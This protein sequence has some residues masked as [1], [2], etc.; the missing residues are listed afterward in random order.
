MFQ[1]RALRIIFGPK[2]QEVA[3]G[4][5]RLHSEEFHNLYASSNVIRV[6]KSRRIS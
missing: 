2:R 6:I 4:W 5:R 1:Y 3:E